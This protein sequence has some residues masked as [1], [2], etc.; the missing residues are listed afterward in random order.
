[1]NYVNIAYDVVTDWVKIKYPGFY[2]VGWQKKSP[3]NLGYKKQTWGLALDQILEHFFAEIGF[4]F[5]LT[6]HEVENIRSKTLLELIHILALKAY[7]SPHRTQPTLLQ[8]IRQ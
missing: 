7:S 5:K 4:R 6:S 2:K 1:M 8:E 3:D